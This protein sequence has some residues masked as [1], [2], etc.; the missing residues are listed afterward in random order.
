[1]AKTIGELRKEG[2]SFKEIADIGRKEQNKKSSSQKSSS[3]SGGGGSSSSSSSKVKTTTYEDY[4]E[5]KAKKGDSSAKKELDRFRNTKSSRSGGSSSSGPVRASNKGQQAEIIMTDTETGETTR[6]IQDLES[7]NTISSSNPSFTREDLIKNVTSNVGRENSLRQQSLQQ[8]TITQQQLQARG[9]PVQ[10]ADIVFGFSAPAENE[11]NLNPVRFFVAPYQAGGKIGDYLYETIDTRG[12]NVKQ[13]VTAAKEF[14]QREGIFGTGNALIE[15]T[16]TAFAEDPFGFFG[17]SV[18][19]GGA[20]KGART[21]SNAARRARTEVNPI[22]MDSRSVQIDT[23]GNRQGLG[24]EAVET[25]GRF[26]VRRGKNTEVVDV[27]ASGLI[28]KETRAFGQKDPNTYTTTETFN[29][30]RGRR[31]F[32]RDNIPNSQKNTQNALSREFGSTDFLE[33]NID[34]KVSGPKTRARTTARVDGIRQ[35]NQQIINVADETFFSKTQNVAK[36][37]NEDIFLT[38]TLNPKT[39]DVSVATSKNIRGKNTKVPTQ[40]FFTDGSISQTDVFYNRRDIMKSSPDKVVDTTASSRTIDLNKPTLSMDEFVATKSKPQKGRSQQPGV[41]DTTSRIEGEAPMSMEGFL[42]SQLGDDAQFD[43]VGGAA[44]GTSSTSQ[45]KFVDIGVSKKSSTGAQTQIFEEP[46]R[47][48]T[49]TPSVSQSQRDITSFENPFETRPASTQ[50]P[51][52]SNLVKRTIIPDADFRPVPSVS[53]EQSPVNIQAQDFIQ[54]QSPSQE[55]KRSP[56]Q[57][58]VFDTSMRNDQIPRRDVT[59]DFSFKSAQT[60][61]NKQIPSFDSPTGPQRP[62]P[63][64]KPPVTPP[65]RPRLDLDLDFQPKSSKRKNFAMQSLED[66]GRYISS[67]GAALTG[68]TSK[69]PTQDITGLKVRAIQLNGRNKR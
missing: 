35:G 14:V 5:S 61:G 2:K 27:D 23:S 67:L 40:D 3:S 37:D 38:E 44:A 47:T 69:N 15:G 24:I 50:V 57:E 41:V 63:P 19:G 29:L 11:V 28:N 56:A 8:Q 31:E 7:G 34:V 55:K 54:S 43:K 62:T 32:F 9:K 42:K 20:V 64:I 66:D 33:G 12:S 22:D 17:E 18:A 10:G 51:I 6:T 1:M 25:K 65:N 60:T 36:L 30:D 46:K 68:K 4:L 13:D 59:F 49:S 53:F 45:P 58:P 16:A 39:Q 52:S 26:E 48:E 21:A